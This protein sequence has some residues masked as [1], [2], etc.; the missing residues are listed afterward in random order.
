MACASSDAELVAATSGFWA[1]YS[2]TLRSVLVSSSAFAATRSWRRTFIEPSEFATSLLWLSCSRCYNPRIATPEEYIV[3]DQAADVAVVGVGAM[4]AMAMWQLAERG[5]RVVGIEQFDVGHQRGAAGGETRIFRTAYKEGREY[6][7]LL[8]RAGELWGELESLTGTSLLRR[9]GALTLGPQDHPEIKEVMA[10]AEAYDLP[11]EVMSADTA[12]QRFPQHRMRSDEVA[13]LDP[14]G[15]L[16]RPSLAIQAAADRA[17][18][19][20]ARLERRRRVELVRD[21]GSRVRVQLEGED[22]IVADRAVVCVGPWTRELL[23]AVGALFEVRRSVLHWFA[24]DAP[25]GFGPDRFPVGIRRSDGD[26]N[27]SFFPSIDGATIKVNLHI[28]KMVVPDPSNFDGTIDADYSRRVAAGIAP[29]LNGV[30]PEATRGAG[31]IEGYSP[32]NHS[33]IGSPPGM[34]RVTALAAFSG[35]GFKMSPTIGELA[36]DLATSGMSSLPHAHMN[37]ARFLGETPEPADH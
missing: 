16:L 31:F 26:S 33:L 15:G 21:E 13:L 24:V 22:A 18:Q 14:S 30:A 37:L 25:A 27:F 35:H 1:M 12:M 19:L 29:W 4:G 9:T 23:P 20:G 2:A 6:V 28:P 7:P 8:R 32:D 3:S 34:P 17:L 36:A 10:S 5:L 11:L